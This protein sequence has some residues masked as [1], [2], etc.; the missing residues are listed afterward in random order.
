[1][2]DRLPNTRPPRV[3]V[4]M[5]VYNDGPF[6]AQAISAVLAQDYSDF[7]L[8][9]SDNASTDGTSEICRSFQQR[10]NRIR[11]VRHDHN[12]GAV[13]NFRH[14]YEQCHGEYFMWA[15]GHDVLRPAFVAVC[16]R[17]LDEQT[18]VVLAY[19]EIR[20]IDGDD[21]PIAGTVS[22]NIDT[23]GQ[24][25]S[26]RTRNV[27]RDLYSCHMIYGL[28]RKSALDRCRHG[29]ICRGPDHV[30]LMELSLH[31][32]IARVAQ[33]LLDLRENRGEQNNRMSYDDY[34]RGQLK[35]LDPNAFGRGNLRPH[36]RWALEH[37]KG[38]LH[39]DIP[40]SQRAALAP[41]VVHAF[42]RRWRIYLR[43][44][45]FTPLTAS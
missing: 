15:G 12:R 23:R 30:L 29:I 25:L 14:V 22:D 19:P 20:Q 40:L 44:E 6:V 42:W 27:I 36:W 17:V 21:V 4:G 33:V 43:R 7:E 35:R 9:I 18:D 5:P 31:G 1:M 2:L 45:I 28:F 34:M 16:A 39:A 13:W 26:Q 3:S 10:D 32:T 11:Y 24:S 38:V 41:L 37:L 8:F